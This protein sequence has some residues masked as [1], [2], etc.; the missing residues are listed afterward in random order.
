MTLMSQRWDGLLKTRDSFVL[1]RRHWHSNAAMLILPGV[2]SRF[3]ADP[4]SIGSDEPASR[5]HALLRLKIIKRPKTARIDFADCKYL[6][7]IL[8]HSTTK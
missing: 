7:S 3:S 4:V 2:D 1:L 5:H 8:R 6:P